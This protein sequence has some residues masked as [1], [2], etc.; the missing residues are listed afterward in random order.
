M[1]TSS[2][3]VVVDVW[4]RIEVGIYMYIYIYIYV[5]ARISLP[6]IY[7]R[8][9]ISLVCNMSLGECEVVHV[10]IRHVVFI[11]DRYTCIH[12]YMSIADSSVCY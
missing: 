4:A 8:K 9:V 10:Y 6:G 5:H 3:L 1:Y 12:V 2:I 7:V 11:F